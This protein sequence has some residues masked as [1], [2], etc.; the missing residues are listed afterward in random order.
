MDLHDLV[1]RTGDAVEML[2]LRRGHKGIVSLNDFDWKGAQIVLNGLLFKRVSLEGVDIRPNFVECIIEDSEF[3]RLR[4]YAHFWGAAN[5]WLRCQF[6][7]IRL[8]D[9]ISPQS[10]FEKCRFEDVRLINYR[11]C[12]TVFS[13]CT[14]TR[15]TLFGMKTTI[16]TRHSAQPELDKSLNAVFSDCF[17]NDSIFRNCYL[18]GIGFRR[19]TFSNVKAENCDFD[20]VV[21]DNQWWEPASEG[22]PFIAFLDEVV[23]M[24]GQRLGVSSQAHCAMKAYR[25]D[26]V[27]GRTASRDYSV[28]LFD[29]QVPYQDLVKIEDGLDD[30]EARYPF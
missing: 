11:P 7:D 6:V 9:V 14:F 2:G 1:N 20:G 24:I 23:E 21:S 10:R 12:T 27:S 30:I 28:C 26:F 8:Q 4:S 19:S 25:D 3:R 13:Q 5:R 17:F 22:D 15:S 29:G 16:A 18:K